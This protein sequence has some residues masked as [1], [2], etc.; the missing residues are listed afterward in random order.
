MCKVQGVKCKDSNAASGGSCPPGTE[1]AG[2]IPCG[3]PTR[4]RSVLAGVHARGW[5]QLGYAGTTSSWVC[6]LCIYLCI[7]LL[8][9]A[10]ILY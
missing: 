7:V 2:Q 8:A 6:W 5:E 4:E 3:S 1:G 9:V 10:N